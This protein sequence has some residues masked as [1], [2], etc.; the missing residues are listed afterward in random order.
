MKSFFSTRIE[1]NR[2]YISEII[3]QNTRKKK[4]TDY[5]IFLS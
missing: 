3:I 2:T 4:Y 1:Q 5:P